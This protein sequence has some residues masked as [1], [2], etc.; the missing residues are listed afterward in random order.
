V[1]QPLTKGE[2]E[3]R[4]FNAKQALAAAQRGRDAKTI[5]S[6]RARVDFYKRCRTMGA[7]RRSAASEKPMRA[8]R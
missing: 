5:R 6:C 4:L 1:T 7:A 8:E 2:I 3:R